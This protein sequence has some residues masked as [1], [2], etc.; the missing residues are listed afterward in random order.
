MGIFKSIA[1]VGI[2]KLVKMGTWVW[3]K[4]PKVINTTQLWFILKQICIYNTLDQKDIE[5][6]HVTWNLFIVRC[7]FSWKD[8]DIQSSQS[9]PYQ[10]MGITSPRTW[11]FKAR[12]HVTKNDHVNSHLFPN[13][14]PS[15]DTGSNIMCSL[16]S[17]TTIASKTTIADQ[18]HHYLP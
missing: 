4:N 16:Q 3:K 10:Q 14:F 11:A 6:Q 7:S 5:F 13:I 12:A 15:C 1:E 8:K 18:Y 17:N 2:W 9:F